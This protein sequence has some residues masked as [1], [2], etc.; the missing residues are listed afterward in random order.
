MENKVQV[1][2]STPA[3]GT[4][5]ICQA[6]RDP[7]GPSGPTLSPAQDTSS[8]IL[9]LRALPR[10]SWS[11]GRLGKAKPS[12]STAFAILWKLFPADPAHGTGVTLPAEADFGR[13]PTL[14]CA[15][16]SHSRPCSHQTNSEQV[17]LHVLCSSYHRCCCWGAAR[18]EAAGLQGSPRS[19]PWQRRARSPHQA[20]TRGLCQ[21]R[22]GVSIHGGRKK[23]SLKALV[24]P[25]ELQGL[26]PEWSTHV[27]LPYTLKDANCV[28][29]FPAIVPDASQVLPCGYPLALLTSSRC[30]HYLLW[31]VKSGPP[32]AFPAPAF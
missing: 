20:P 29:I 11:S 25:S 13:P 30:P 1:L 5:G 14:S 6:G 18:A 19:L 3:Q 17:L 10:S 16:C 7:Q 28:Y 26:S 15:G 9:C 31:Y 2:C 12:A 8:H 24:E 4:H 22:K 27:E 23:R 21:L 32:G